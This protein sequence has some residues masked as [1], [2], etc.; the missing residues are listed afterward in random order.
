M[1]YHFSLM[2]AVHSVLASSASQPFLFDQDYP[3]IETSSSGSSGEALISEINMFTPSYN[4]EDMFTHVQF[5]PRST[6]VYSNGVT[7]SQKS[8]PWLSSHCMD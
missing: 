8:G 6:E 7:S 4:L 5:H 2:M 1:I 3:L